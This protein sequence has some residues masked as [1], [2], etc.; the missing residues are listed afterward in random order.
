MS[1]VDIPAVVGLQ[2]AFLHGSIVTELGPRFL[3]RFH[4]VALEHPASR[5]FVAVDDRGAVV[6]FAL[7]S[8]DVHAFHAH[9]K[10]RVLVP[11]ITALLSPSRIAL[12]ASLARM[13][14]ESEPEPHLPGELLLLT[15]DPRARR[16]GVGRALLQSL[17][18]A[19]VQAGMWRYRVAV[20]SQ[21]AEARAFYEALQFVHEQDRLVLG[22]PMAYLT[23]QLHTR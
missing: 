13:V 18:G 17:E 21:L 15:V 10:P 9:V 6:G 11:M 4:S 1:A 8:L 20:R 19:F 22:L 12:T 7:G 5:A 14:F 2:T 23:K 3:T 16:G